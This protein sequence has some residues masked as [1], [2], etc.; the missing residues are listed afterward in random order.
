MLLLLL[1]ML[2]FSH[3][4]LALLSPT[5]PNNCVVFLLHMIQCYPNHSAASTYF[6]QTVC[7]LLQPDKMITCQLSCVIKSRILRTGYEHPQFHPSHNLQIVPLTP[8]CSV[9]LM[10]H[11]VLFI[12]ISLCVH[13]S[14]FYF[15]LFFFSVNIYETLF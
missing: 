6:P 15:P 2:R 8:L 3:S 5:W 9:T 7:V 12:S 11:S 1:I 4:F 10:F 13:V 14:F